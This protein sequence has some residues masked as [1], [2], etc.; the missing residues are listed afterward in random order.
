MAWQ[1]EGVSIN[2]VTDNLNSLISLDFDNMEEVE[3]VQ[4]GATADSSASSG[5]YVNIIT[6]SGGNDFHG[7]I[8]GYYTNENMYK[9]LFSQNYIDIIG[10]RMPV[11]PIFETQASASLG[12]PIVK[13]KIWFYSSLG[14]FDTESTG[15][16]I[17]ATILGTSYDLYSNTTRNIDGFL[18]LTT[19]LNPSM[20][21]F[22][23]LNAKHSNRQ[24]Y[25]G[26]N[27]GTIESA[28]DMPNKW[29][30]FGSANLSWTLGQ[31]TIVDFR[32][33]FV[34]VTSPRTMQEGTD[35]SISYS[36]N[37]VPG[38]PGTYRWGAPYQYNSK[39]KQQS[40]QASAKLT[41]YMDNFLGGD[42]EFGMGDRIR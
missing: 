27:R 15:N 23:Q 4:A 7:H 30:V 2:A 1:V 17:P 20:K 14:F 10:A 8:Q 35:G 3:I 11:T 21:L 9:S 38:Y 31:N 39:D 37:R 19:Q 16:F 22:A 42:H 33:G 41:H 25:G 5:S 34:D 26:G 32:A 13:D 18:K 24:D 28:Y 6:K 29:S 12:G 36:D 40:L